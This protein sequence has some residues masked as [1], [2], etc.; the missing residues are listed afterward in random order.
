V[1]ELA[2]ATTE[3]LTRRGQRLAQFTVA[4]NIAEGA[5]AVTAGSGTPAPRRHLVPS[6]ATT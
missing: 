4:Y 2:A 5:V 1:S 3:R 6:A